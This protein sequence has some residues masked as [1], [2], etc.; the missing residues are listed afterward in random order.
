MDNFI[1]NAI[2]LS[3]IILSITIITSYMIETI[4]LLK[5][6]TTSLISI[7]FIQPIKSILPKSTG[8][9]IISSSY[10]ALFILAGLLISPPQLF[11][12]LSQYLLS[13]EYK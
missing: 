10:I 12:Y 6:S 3:S 1:L 5:T 11:I 7:L 13:L 4:V 8:H 2:T 9:F